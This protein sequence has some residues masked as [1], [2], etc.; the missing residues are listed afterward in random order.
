[1]IRL[2]IVDHDIRVSAGCDTALAGIEAV[3]LGGIL[4]ENAAH[5]GQVDA[6]AGHTGGIHHLTPGLHA[7]QTAGNGGEI[8]LSRQLL[9]GGKGA[10]VGGYC[11]YAAL[12]Q[13][14]P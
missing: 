3:Q 11:L 12:L 7:G 1:M 9:L 14:G 10:V 13:S 8:S 4:A 5:C 2:R 6:A